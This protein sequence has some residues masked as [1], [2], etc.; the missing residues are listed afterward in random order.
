MRNVEQN[1]ARVYPAL[2]LHL[3]VM[4]TAVCV[5][6]W[7]QYSRVTVEPEM[8]NFLGTKSHNSLAKYY[9]IHQ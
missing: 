6:I 2:V 3:L 9:I 4:G 5:L 1:S 7:Y 8:E